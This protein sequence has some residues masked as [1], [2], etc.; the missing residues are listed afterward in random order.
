MTRAD[1]PEAAHARHSSAR[2]GEATAEE[3][4]QPNKVRR[5]S[6]I[7]LLLLTPLPPHPLH[8]S[9][10]LQ[11]ALPPLLSAGFVPARLSAGRPRSPTRPALLRVLQW[12]APP[13]GVS[14]RETSRQ[15]W[16][17]SSGLCMPRKSGSRGGEL[18]PSGLLDLSAQGG[19]RTLRAKGPDLMGRYACE[20]VKL[21][22]K[23]LGM[24]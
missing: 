16:R 21:Q 22:I 2:K 13:G 7:G 3:T 8:S 4:F 17:A 1:F 18:C 24:Q 15:L 6:E 11:S 9:R 14:T 10:N 19:R 23:Q 12:A 5:L 20:N